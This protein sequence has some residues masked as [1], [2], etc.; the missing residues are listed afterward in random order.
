MDPTMQSPRRFSLPPPFD[1]T[2][3]SGPHFYPIKAWVGSISQGNTP[4]QA[5]EALLRHASPL[6]SGSSFDGRVLD[7]PGFGQI[8]QRVDPDRMM[9]VNTT[10]PGHRL[11]PGNVHRWV[12]QEGDDLYVVTHGY[13]TGELPWLN[14][15]TSG[16][17]WWESHHKIRRE[18]N[19]YTPLGYPM[20][21]MNGTAGAAPSP[22]SMDSAEPSRGLISDEP[23]DFS[24]ARPP[25]FFRRLRFG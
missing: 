12:V 15:K 2:I 10:L 18:L 11:D 25:I 20:D 16:P 9:V 1:V 23:M 5:F 3:P 21:E 13:G 24:V 7:I 4:Q 6:Q 19:P 17:G 8:Q 22:N 14:E